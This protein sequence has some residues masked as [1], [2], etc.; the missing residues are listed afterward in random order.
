MTAQHLLMETI[1]LHLSTIKLLTKQIALHTTKRS[2]TNSKWLLLQG[3]LLCKALAKAEKV[4]A[5]GP[6]FIYFFFF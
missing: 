3:T 6:L 2:Q 1:F 5:A 4:S